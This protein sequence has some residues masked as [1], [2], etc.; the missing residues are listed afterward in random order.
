MFDKVLIANRGEIAVRVART[1]R[2][3]GIRSV[4][5]F[6]DLDHDAMHV[7]MADEAY[8]LSGD[9][10]A[11]TYLNIDAV[12]DVLRTSQ[13]SAVHPGYGFL[14]E[15]ATFAR[16]VAQ[17]GATF[18]GPP[19]EA[20]DTMGSKIS[21]RIAAH[22]AGAPTVP[23]Q[24]EPV[25]DAE[26]VLLFGARYGWPV[27]IKASYGGG[28]R[29]M[30][31]VHFPEDA[32][33]AL[34]VARREAASSFGRSE[35][36]LEHYL[37]HP[38]HIEMQI[39]ADRFGNAIWLG[40]RD[41]SSQRRHQKLLEETPAAD[42]SKKTR[43]AMGEAAIHIARACN[44][45]GA[46][47]IEFL[48]QDGEFFFLEMNTR[49]QVEHPVTEAVTGLD[50]VALQL[51]VASGQPIGMKQR[52]VK[53]CGHAIE[54]RVN[55]E[56]PTNG[57]FSPSPGTITRF[58]PPGG[59]GV[60][61]D[62][63]YETGDVVSPYFDNLVAKVIVWAK[64]R[65]DAR[66]RMLRALDETIVEGVATTIPVAR[67]IL[68]NDEFIAGTHSTSLV[69]E[70]LDFAAIPTPLPSEG[71]LDNDGRVLRTVEAQVDGRLYKVRVYVPQAQDTVAPTRE[72]GPGARRGSSGG[73]RP[74]D[75]T[76]TVPM[77]GTIIELRVTVG[78]V[79][80]EN[81]V[82]CVLEAMKMENP[83]RAQLAGTIT[84]LLVRPGD[85]CG[86]GDT[87]AVIQ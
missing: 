77:Q 27:A 18:I 64:N 6:S 41:C 23:G 25:K 3:L 9:S 80:A 31:V 10:P 4:V 51:R 54:C 82:I 8:A 50:L 28:G 29:G 34:D 24:D 36:Y 13:A 22:S 58:R 75:G 66:R 60:R 32:S 67:A 78:D 84:E 62:T 56:D 35:V 26:Q 30:K 45:E 20:I 79:V 69:E 38:R 55:A 19:P 7:R 40:E 44:Y 61:T 53:T 39:F 16:A 85:S 81:D 14:A 68:E 33:E 11:E 59:P 21:A 48:Y 43:K 83:I 15:N 12:I 65:E 74:A 42:F 37:T 47:T 87:V 63:G 76:V 57:A 52:D 86:P 2:E 71:S 17:A 5:V 46:G 73:T 49:L 1:C 72:R 70:R